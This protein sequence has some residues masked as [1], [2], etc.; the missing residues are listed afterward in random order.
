M[1]RKAAAER[2]SHRKSGHPAR[3]LNDAGRIVGTAERKGGKAN[4]FVE[5]GNEPVQHFDRKAIELLAAPD[6]NTKPGILENACEF[7]ELAERAFG[8]IHR[9][10]GNTGAQ[11]RERPM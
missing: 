7:V 5:I 6:G 9:P 10:P 3:G 11:A 4:R 8:T 1:L 2:C